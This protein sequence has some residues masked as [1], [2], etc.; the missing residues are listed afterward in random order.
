MLDKARHI[1]KRCMQDSFKYAKE[2]WD[3]SDRPPDFK[4][5][6]LVLVSTL[7]FN[8]IKVPKKLKNFFEG[9]FMIKELHGHHAVQ[10]ELTGELMN[11][12]PNFAVSLINPYMSSD[13]EL[14]LLGN[15][16]PLKIPPLEEGEERKN[17]KVLKERRTKNRKEREFLVRYRKP[18]Q[19]D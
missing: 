18:A 1:A 15:K 5:G 3:K 8:K 2:R 10:L 16:T 4:V 17:V 19:E 6:G 14:F 11:K 13:K 9:T 7:N 12:T